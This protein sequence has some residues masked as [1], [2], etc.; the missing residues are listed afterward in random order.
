[1]M[2]T[3]IRLVLLCTLTALFAT[4]AATWLTRSTARAD[5][6]ADEA[7]INFQL[8]AERY[9]SGDYRSA[10]AHFLVSNRLAPNRKVRFNIARTFQ[11]LAQFPEAYRW[12]LVALEGEADATVRKQLEDTLH[13]IEAEVAILDVKS[14]PEGATVFIDRRDLGS[15]ATTPSRI[16]LPEGE[17]RVL[18]EFA[19]Y[20]DLTSEP[21]H[22][23]KGRVLPLTFELRRITGAV[24]VTAEAA[25]EVRVDTDNRAACSTPCRLDLAPGP[26]SLHFTRAG[27]QVKPLQVQVTAGESVLVP[28]EAMP[29]VGSIVVTAEERDA[30]VQ[31]DGV[32]VGFTPLVVP[33]VAVGERK[34]RLSLRG[35]EPV[36]RVVQVQEGKEA[37]LR[38]LV[39]VPSRT[40]T[41]ASRIAQSIDEAPAS[42]SIISEQEL[43]AFRYPTI[44]EALRGQRGV[45]LSYD[46]A[47]SSLTLRGLGQPGDYSNRTLVLSD[48][49]TLND[50][51][52]SQAYIGYDGR[53]ELGDVER[54]ELVRGPGSVLYGTGAV[55]GVINLVPHAAPD[56]A[57]AEAR[58]MT[59]DTR[60]ARAR[61][62]GGIPFGRSGRGDGLLLSAAGAHG[63]G[64]R[65]ALTTPSPRASVGGVNRFDA[66][67]LQGRLTHRDLTVQAFFALREQD[68]PQGAYGALVGDDHNSLRDTRALL[69]ARYEPTLRR[70]VRLFTR[71]FGNAYWFEAEQAYPG[72]ASG[73]RAL[74]DER[75]QGLWFG[76]EGRFVATL[77]DDLRLTAGTEI[78]VS[79]IASLKGSSTQAGAYLD[80]NEAYRIYAGYGLL[81]WQ[82]QRWLTVSAGARADAWSTFGAT[83]NPRVA[84]ILRPTQEDVLKLMG[85]R[86]FRAPS[87]YELRYTD[88]G[89]TQ[90]ASGYGGN[91]LTP[92]LVWSAELEYTRA[93]GEGWSGLGSAHAQLAEDL[94][95]QA[96]TD[97]SL[98]G[99]PVY[100]R[101]SA[102]SVQTLG[103]D[104]E[105]RREF[106]AGW[107]FASSYGYL[108]ARYEDAAAGGGD[109]RVPNA[110]R[111]FGSLRGVA[112]ISTTMRLAMRTS[113][114][115][116][117]RIAAN[118]R[119]Q[120][121][122]ALVSDLVLTGQVAGS[123]LDY[124]LGLYNLFDWRFALP[125]DP[126][127]VTRTMPQPGRTLLISLGLRR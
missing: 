114:E 46:G 30:L 26:H 104:V 78:Q 101:N 113:L 3:A 109:H 19:G 77:T 27:Y 64:E 66:A 40:V 54:I 53:V 119:A 110:P 31:L 90:V 56:R 50:N 74:V 12:C 96:D 36:E 49:S 86:A 62:A 22:A 99:S 60:T 11:R 89:A 2:R 83:I 112:P 127:F 25:T 84:L 67:T 107:M 44:Y 61:I 10:L 32:S 58:I 20:E 65:I 51:V 102:S 8:G 95:E 75:Y 14:S 34:V 4:T 73:S 93:L 9:Q 15:V 79:P 72:P 106:R 115:A 76:A 5:G 87:I 117:R 125:T 91:D 82:V 71:V 98:Q 47:Y 124:A 7:E 24:E 6:V 52:L 41:S 81:E 42:V 16:A 39:L 68:V 111:H 116:P 48:G 63:E 105:L 100:Y 13:S 70:R 118:T 122:T 35:F 1:M 123:G 103:G 23:I 29:W 28:V 92:E 45:A 108:L 55:T 37:V 97:A 59:N 85:G 80:A 33:N 88:G 94:I 17:H 121:S 57:F 38:D 21:V 18:L 43:D 69:E 120:T 126:T